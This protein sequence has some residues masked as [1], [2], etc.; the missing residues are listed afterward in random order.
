M[1]YCRSNRYTNICFSTKKNCNVKVAIDVL[2]ARGLL[3]N[4]LSDF[5]FFVYKNC[6]AGVASGLETDIP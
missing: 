2:A 3:F 1:L 4:I 6:N 5:H